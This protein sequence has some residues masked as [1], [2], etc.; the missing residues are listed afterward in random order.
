M[1][2]VMAQQSHEWSTQPGRIPA[3]NLHEFRS[4]LIFSSIDENFLSNHSDTPSLL[5]RF[6]SGF[7]ACDC[8]WWWCRV[9]A[10]AAWCCLAPCQRRRDWCP[11]WCA[12]T[13][14]EGVMFQRWIAFP[15]FIDCCETAR[16]DAAFRYISGRGSLDELSE[17]VGVGVGGWWGGQMLRHRQ[18]HSWIQGH[19]SQPHHS[20]SL[21]L[22][23]TSCVFIELLWEESKQRWGGRDVGWG[24]ATTNMAISNVH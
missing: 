24:G 6:S 22:S 8:R 19:R 16:D 2:E 10:H 11:Q 4:W 23:A 9:A 3:V 18:D 17:G 5:C 20:L 12:L 1:P 7:F 21:S 14:S 15:V 13:V